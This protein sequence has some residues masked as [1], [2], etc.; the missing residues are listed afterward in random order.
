[1]SW[2][3][4]KRILRENFS[5]L[6]TKTHASVHLMTKVQRPDES[7]Q[8]YIY[9][10]SELVKMLPGLKPIQVTDPLK[11]VIFNKHLFNQEIKKLVAKGYD[12]NLKEAFD[13]ALAAE[14]KAKKF[15]GLTDDDPSVMTITA[16]RQVNQVMA[17]SENEQMPDIVYLNQTAVDGTQPTNAKFS[18]QKFHTNCYKCGERGHYARECPQSLAAK[19]IV[20]PP[21]E[22]PITHVLAAQMDTPTT[23]MIPTVGP[24]KVVQTITSEEQ[25]PMGTWNALLEQLGQAQAENNK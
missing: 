22:P 10:F 24:P 3:E 16:R 9:Q 13:S 21:A 25:L 12:Q 5:N 19:Q 8:E 20:L 14:R 17:T 18:R 7:L 11:I 15:K 23:Q 1:M 2:E 4:Y 6:Q